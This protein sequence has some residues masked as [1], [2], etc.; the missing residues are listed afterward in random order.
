[1]D[2]FQINDMGEQTTTVVW[3]KFKGVMCRILIS[4]KKG[5]FKKR[6]RR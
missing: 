4:E 6:N 1:M 2:F 5:N 3:D